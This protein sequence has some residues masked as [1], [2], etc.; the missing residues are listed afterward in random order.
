[1]DANDYQPRDNVFIVMVIVVI[2]S[3]VLGVSSWFDGDLSSATW[4]FAVLAFC[5]G[6]IILG[7]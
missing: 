3:A 7:K 2:F 6:A 4:F 1:M 5:A